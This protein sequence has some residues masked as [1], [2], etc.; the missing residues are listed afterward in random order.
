MVILDRQKMANIMELE[1]LFREAVSMKG[2]GK[3]DFRMVAVEKYVKM[4]HIT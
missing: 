1:D 4:V 3:T 2:N